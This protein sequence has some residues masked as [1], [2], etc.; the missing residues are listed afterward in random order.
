VNK[1]FL[2]IENDS[3][4]C[5]GKSWH[6]F[7]NSFFLPTNVSLE[8]VQSEFK[9][10]LPGKFKP[11]PYGLSDIPHDFNDDNREVN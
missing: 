8:F 7:P 2:W 4:V 6:Q 5:V 1:H 10:Q 9:G 3:I 11:W